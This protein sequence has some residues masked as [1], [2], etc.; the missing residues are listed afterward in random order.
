MSYKKTKIVTILIVSILLYSLSFSKEK[1]EAV[2]I[3]AIKLKLNKNKQEYIAEGNVV[4]RKKNDVLE[5]DTV[6]F[7]QNTMKSSAEGNV[8]YTSK[9]N[10]IYAS[11]ANMDFKTEQGN[12]YNTHIN[13]DEGNYRIKGKE[14]E[15][16]GEFSY[17]IE[18]G[19]FTTCDGENP[20]WSITGKKMDLTLGEFLVSKHTVFWVKSVPV[21]YLP[22][23]VAPIKLDR[24]SGLLIP[25]VS[26]SDRKG[27][28]YEQAYFWAI[29]E[30]ND[31]TINLQHMEKRGEKIGL[32]YR[33]A[34]SST[35]KGV[36]AYDFLDDKKKGDETKENKDFSYEV[37]PNR[38]NY[39][40][41]WFKSSITQ[42]APFDSTLKIDLDVVSD[43]DYLREFKDSNTGFNKSKEYYEENFS[44]TI[45]DYS[46]NK[47][48]NKASL[49]KN[50]QKYNINF[51]SIWYDDVSI[52]MTDEEDYSLQR[53]F[54]I[55]FNGIKQN[56]FKT[57]LFYEIDSEVVN[58]YRKDKNE[59]YLNGNRA[60][61]V[62]TLYLPLNYKSYFNFEPSLALR[63]TEWKNLSYQDPDIKTERNLYDLKLDLNSEVFRIFEIKGDNQTNKVKHTIKPQIVY[64]YIPED[65]NKYP[66]FDETDSIAKTKT[67][68]FSITQ[69]LITKNSNRK[70]YNEVLWAKL[71]QSYDLNKEKDE[72]PYS[73]IFLETELKPNQYMSFGYDK[74]WSPYTKETTEETFTTSASDKRGDTLVLEN[75][76]IKADKTSSLY[77]NTLIKTVP[78]IDIFYEYEIDKYNDKEI[79]RSYGFI[80]RQ[81]CWSILIR[82][83]QELED[84]KIEFLI[85]FYGLGEVNASSRYYYRNMQ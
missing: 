50:W 36:L 37:T 14:V 26:I 3:N 72:R 17:E 52:K 10:T 6:F 69:N 43:T 40:R 82:R 77:L 44:R 38:N 29:D 4:V 53:P 63:R 19:R 13:L 60:D 59:T 70:T 81:K 83:A 25:T 21:I 2:K 58:F 49:S 32:E 16:T 22:Y 12:L 65:K 71:S 31:A 11:K 9:G 80:Y 85:N 1:T 62:T 15:K 73:D 48:V 28:V 33:Y 27:F 75:R 61:I 35:S 20:D 55:E 24:E 46:E 78:D 23:L 18:K 64:E 8:I 41:Y 68:T 57:K 56:L 76:Y 30:A 7:N 51:S 5:A 66:Y 67:I 84:K 34:L 47:R 39:N 42:D 79:T 54:F 45:T 74:K